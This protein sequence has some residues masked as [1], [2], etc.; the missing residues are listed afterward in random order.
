MYGMRVVDTLAKVLHGILSCDVESTEQGGV[1]K[2]KGPGL[3]FRLRLL[4]A[5]VVLG[6]QSR[7]E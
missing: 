1:V 7:L 2:L 6:W 4:P 3:Y 5:N